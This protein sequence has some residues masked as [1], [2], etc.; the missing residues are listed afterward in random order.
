MKDLFFNELGLDLFN[1]E[2]L[3]MACPTHGLPVGDYTENV[4]RIL[5]LILHIKAADGDA[6]IPLFVT[7]HP[8]ATSPLARRKN[9]LEADRFELYVF[10]N[11]TFMELANGY[12]ELNDPDEQLKNFLCQSDSKAEAYIR[13]VTDNGKSPMSTEEIQETIIAFRNNIDHDYIHALKIGMPMAGG[14]GIG[15]DRLVMWLTGSHSIRDVIAFPL[16]KRKT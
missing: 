2:G 13:D 16:T 14:L 11:N 10:Y 3:A 8:A 9:N 15:V 4:D 1:A 6:E 5:D 12:S 7:G